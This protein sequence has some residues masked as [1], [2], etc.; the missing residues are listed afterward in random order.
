MFTG[1]PHVLSE[2]EEKMHREN[3]GLPRLCKECGADL[4]AALQE[5]VKPVACSRSMIVCGFPCG[6]HV[7][8]FDEQDPCATQ[9]P[10]SA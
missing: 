4:S 1:R 6:R 9:V 10:M 8:D 2:Y 3:A 7:Q 5:L